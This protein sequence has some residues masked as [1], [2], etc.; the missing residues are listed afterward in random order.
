MKSLNKNEQ[1]FGTVEIIMLVVIIVLIG[2]VGYLVYKNH[3]QPTKVVTITRTITASSSPTAPSGSGYTAA[4][5]QWVKLYTDNQDLIGTAG[6]NPP[7]EQAIKDLQN[8]LKTDK[9]TSDYNT[10]INNLKV[11]LDEPI[12]NVSAAQNVILNA[13]DS[14]LMTFFDTPNI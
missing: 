7:I 4:K 6:Q 1:G 11:L 12:T 2:T 8:G 3:H 14:Y 5:Q 9:N 13:A 10:A